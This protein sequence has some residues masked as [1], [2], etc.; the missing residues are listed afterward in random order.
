MRAFIA[1]IVVAS[2]L[3]GASAY[4]LNDM[5]DEKAYQTFST[6]G[7]RVGEPGSNLVGPSWYAPS[8]GG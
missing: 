4:V 3:A 8:Q 5:T 7:A 1:S 6:T 2:V